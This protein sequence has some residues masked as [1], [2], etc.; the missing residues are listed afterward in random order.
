MRVCR[1]NEVASICA[2]G[3]RRNGGIDGS[4]IISI[5]RTTKVEVAAAAAAA[6]VTEW[7]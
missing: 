7:L 3:T 4:R 5:N 6:A 1:H 2:C